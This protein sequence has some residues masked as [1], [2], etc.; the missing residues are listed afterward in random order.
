MR[1][2][3]KAGQDEMKGTMR[4]GQGKMETVRNS[5]RSEFKET[6]NK[7]VEGVLASGD[8]WSQSF[9]RELSNEMQGTKR[10]LHKELTEQRASNKSTPRSHAGCA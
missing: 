10:D 8:Q 5:I 3:I 7:L 1:A 9:H 4:T 6:I 2:R